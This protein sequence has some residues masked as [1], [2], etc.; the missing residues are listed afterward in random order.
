MRRAELRGNPRE[1]P[2][3]QA[4]LGQGSL[5]TPVLLFTSPCGVSGTAFTSQTLGGFAMPIIAQIRKVI[6]TDRLLAAV[7]VTWAV[8]TVAWW[9]L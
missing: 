2:A 5:A 4:G 3:G 6:N 7:F 8:T 9:C 1:S